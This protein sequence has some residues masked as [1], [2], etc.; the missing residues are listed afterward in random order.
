MAMPMTGT[1]TEAALYRLL[2]WLSPAFPTGAY[3]YSHGI[4]YAVECGLVRDEA[5]FKTWL[6]GILLRGAG[7]I[8]GPIFAAAYSA[9]AR[10]NLTAL[11]A[12]AERAAAWRGAAELA[13]EAEA[14]GAALLATARAAWDSPRLAVLAEAIQPYRVTLPVAVAMA[15]A[16]AEIELASSLAGYFH[17]F[18]ANLIAAGGRLIPLGQT[19]GQRL[20]AALENAV[21]SAA[22]HGLETTLDGAGAAAP[23]VD[24]CS[25]RHE[26]Q[27]TRLFRS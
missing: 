18:T 17:A 13:L 6:E 5:S 27:Y 7:A 16:A 11:G 14:Q 8:D 22:R 15:A 2:A 23:M 26:M 25:M 19:A 9:A 20:L 24:W 1:I 21:A 12:I 3:S 4:E 10:P